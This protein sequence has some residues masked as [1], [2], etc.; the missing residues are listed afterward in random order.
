[1]PTFELTGRDGHKYRLTAPDENAALAAFSAFQGGGNAPNAEPE[2]PPKA[3]DRGIT[4]DDLVRSVARGIPVLGGAMDRIAAAGDAA[5]GGIVDRGSQAES[6]SE[7]YAEN[8]ANEQR[9]DREFD[10]NS[11]VAST[12]AKVAGGVAGVA[13][14]V[15]AAPA[16][17]G[18]TGTLPQMVARGAASG[19]GLSAA[20]A[21]VRGE[22]VDTAAAVGGATGAAAPLVARAIGAGVR[23][24]RPQPAPSA[25]RTENVAG[26]E[27]PLRESQVTGDAVQSA[28][29]QVLLRGGAG[30]S[31]QAL[32]QGFDDM[33][34]QRVAQASDNI[35]ASLDPTGRVA[36]T[37]PQDAGERVANELAQAEAD[38]V[39]RET[40]AQT[41]AQREAEA[42]RRQV[43]AG[44]AYLPAG[45]GVVADS[46]FTA[47]EQVGLGVQHG[48]ETARQTRTAA[49]RNLR[50]IEGE[51][52]PASMTQIGNSIRNRLNAPRQ[53]D[54]VRINANTPRGA[55]ALQILDEQVGQ[56]RFRN[57]ANTGELIRDASGQPV[58]RPIDG[59]AIEEV[60]K[61]LNTLYRDA[62]MASRA[63]G[64]VQTDVRA[65]SAVIDAFDDHLRTAANSG[66]FSG[67]G[68]AFLRAQ[69]AARDLHRAYRQTFSRQ[70]P[71]DEVGNQV[72]KILGRYVDQ[73]ATPDQIAQIAFGTAGEPGGAMA[74][75]VAQRLRNILGE[76][77]EGWGAYKQGL[78]SLVIDTP[79]GKAPR[80]PDELA[81]RLLGFLHGTKGRGLAQMV[82]T[83]DERR[84]F[85]AFANSQRSLSRTADT[86]DVGKIV[87]KI[88]GADGGAGATSGEVVDYLFSRTGA[89][90]KGV[91]VRLAQ[92]LKNE[93]TPEGWTAVRQ[94]MWAKLTNAGEGK[95]A[96][97]P[98][99]LS[100]R[101]HEFLNESGKSL[102][103]VL[104]SPAERAEMAKLANVYR[105]QIPVAGTTNPSGTAPMLAKIMQQGSRNIL[106]L[107]GGV[108]GGFTGLAVG[109]AG[110]RA[111]RALA[112]RRGQREA[113]RSF[114]GDQPRAPIRSSRVP[115]VAAQGSMPVL[116]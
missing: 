97:G 111:V 57:D 41:L 20:D 94:G 52:D 96:F 73:A 87:A 7:R 84:A 106:A 1:M 95:V 103:H 62:V 64:G 86:S 108:Q 69:Q 23:A 53:G 4:A 19:A 48:A 9:R 89:G 60:R 63:P 50:D 79:A 65:V 18:V 55:E 51:F 99:A 101:I 71:G 29:E 56:L 81:D 78:L 98:Q 82:F 10:E 67:D 21:A 37:A 102:S 2:G 90:N 44:D 28:R 3:P 14:L 114:Y 77:S 34:A 22:E 36:R 31:A 68:Q 92:R 75:K 8:L 12:V 30:E 85:E 35:G 104:F 46:P 61:E 107:L 17:F 43:G 116:D 70:G 49:Y 110:D 39:S 40:A 6:F 32:A 13:P 66:A 16:A 100:Q 72:E 58:R 80:T 115:V 113:V 15:A 88:S 33:A 83:A 109:A 112:N 47:A 91:S 59:N 25:M 105:R 24:L 42:L 54:P 11:P 45:R 74:I 5:L 76:N 27:I 38:R 26:V 93:L